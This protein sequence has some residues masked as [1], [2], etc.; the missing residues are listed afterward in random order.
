MV[1]LD[2]D[3]LSLAYWGRGT[4][5]NNVRRRLADIEP[6]QVWAT[7]ISYEEQTRGWLVFSAKAKTIIEQVKAYERLERHLTNWTKIPLLGFNEKCAVEFQRLRKAVR[8]GTMDLRIAAI[9][10]THGATVI[11][12]NFRDFQK[13]PGFRIEDW[14]VSERAS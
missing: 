4:D 5:A 7:I 9:A 1:V 14:S 8:I 2:T 10:L 11:T 3:H 13:V 6:S 12:R